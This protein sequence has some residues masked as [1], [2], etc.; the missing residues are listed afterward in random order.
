MSAL[1]FL[2]EGKPPENISAKTKEIGDSPPWFQDYTRGLIAK[3][4]AVAAAGYK[5]YPGA[6]RI[7][8]FT[9]YQ[10]K[11]MSMVPNAA[12]SYQPYLRQSQEETQA[13]AQGDSLQA[14]SPYFQQAA[15]RTPEGI[16]S[17]LNPYTQEVVNRIGALSQRQLKENIIPTIQNQFIAGGTFG[18]SR[19]GEALGRAVRDLGEST[20][21][22]QSQALERGYAQAGQQ[23]Q[24]DQAR[25][26]QLGQVSGALTQA[27]FARRLQAADQ[28]G[29]LG[30]MA[31]NLGLAGVAAIQSTGDTQQLY[32][33]RNLDLAYQDFLQQRDYDREQIAFLNQAIR[34]LDI[35]TRQYQE[36]IGPAEYYQPSP[37]TQIAQAASTY[38][39]M[40]RIGSGNK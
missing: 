40:S 33:Q 37:L 2:F 4:N 26:A 22:A 8:P 32:D 15:M 36:R 31:Q 38:A 5:P 25:L 18:G 13:A 1:D 9:E 6:L 19:S 17:Y 30:A 12:M 16:G 27:D 10:Q 28:Y 35:P 39:G 23:M 14:A 24:Q 29:R 11:A 21:A 34:G 3:A 7:A 20:T